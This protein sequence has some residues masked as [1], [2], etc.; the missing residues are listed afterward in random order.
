MYI[1]TPLLFSSSL[2][3]IP[4]QFIAQ[5]RC[6]RNEE[7][8]ARQAFPIQLYKQSLPSQPV[9]Q[10]V[11]R[12][13]IEHPALQAWPAA[14]GK[15]GEQETRSGT[16]T[17]YMRFVFTTPR[18]PLALP[19]LVFENEKERNPPNACHSI[20]AGFL[21]WSKKSLIIRA[22]NALFHIDLEN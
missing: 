2:S 8:Q 6:I 5:P 14:S 17:S 7:T 22:S 18:K 16:S 11:G 20:M 1:Q 21:K 10:P 12:E 9:S 13:R 4:H 15:K 19:S 3:F